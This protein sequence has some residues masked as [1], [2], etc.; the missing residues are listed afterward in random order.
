MV[1]AT[2]GFAWSARRR[3]A[4]WRTWGAARKVGIAS[5]SPVQWNHVA[6]TRGV[7]SVAM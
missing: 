5:R 3:P 2:A 6:T 4:G 7:P 1:T